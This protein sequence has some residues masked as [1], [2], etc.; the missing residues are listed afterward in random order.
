MPDASRLF[1][2]AP[3]ATILEFQPTVSGSCSRQRANAKGFRNQQQPRARSDRSAPSFLDLRRRRI[4]IVSNGRSRFVVW[5]T[6]VARHTPV[7]VPR[8]QRR[9]QRAG[10]RNVFPEQGTASEVLGFSRSLLGVP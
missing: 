4:A 10:D 6:N 1:N 8:L 2:L 3:A 9:N 7:S 5:A